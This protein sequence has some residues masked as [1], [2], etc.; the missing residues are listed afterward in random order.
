LEKQTKTSDAVALSTV[1]TRTPTREDTLRRQNPAQRHSTMD[2][3][4]TT[5]LFKEREYNT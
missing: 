3:V 4:K 2:I 1:Y 5:V